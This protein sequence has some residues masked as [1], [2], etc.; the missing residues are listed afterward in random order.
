MKTMYFNLV[1]ICGTGIAQSQ[2]TITA[3][4]RLS[5]F[6]AGA[7]VTNVCATFSAAALAGVIPA[8]FTGEWRA[9]TV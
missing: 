8:G 6:T 4:P 1:E 3:H 2:V 9:F 7:D 5:S